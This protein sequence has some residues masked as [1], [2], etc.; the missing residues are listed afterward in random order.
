MGIFKLDRAS[1]AMLGL[2]TE[3]AM[4]QVPKARPIAQLSLRDMHSD[5][6]AQMPNVGEA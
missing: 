2:E 6:G 3:L 4:F 5:P 1:I